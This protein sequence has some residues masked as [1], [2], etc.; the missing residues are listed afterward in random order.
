VIKGE[1]WIDGPIDIFTSKIEFDGAVATLICENES[2][3]SWA[4]DCAPSEVGLLLLFL[5]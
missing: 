1:K 4:V 3:N 2:N 5:M